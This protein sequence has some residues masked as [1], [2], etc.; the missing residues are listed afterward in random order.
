V[1]HHK[2]FDRGVIGLDDTHRIHIST[3]YGARTTAG[4]GLYDLHGKSL[5][6]RPGTP[7]PAADHI[8]WH[9]R[10]VFKGLSLTA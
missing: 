7:L 8:G 9:R 10:E 6:P 1:L 5:N 2:L 3:T 4:R